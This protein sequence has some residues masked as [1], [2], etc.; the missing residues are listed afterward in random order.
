[1]GGWGLPQTYDDLKE[2]VG[3]PGRPVFPG[4]HGGASGIATQGLKTMSLRREK[5]L[6]PPR[7]ASPQHGGLQAQ[8]T[9]GV[10]H[11]RAPAAPS[12]GCDRRTPKP[13]R[14]DPAVPKSLQKNPQVTPS[15]P[16][17]LPVRTQRDGRTSHEDAWREEGRAPAGIFYR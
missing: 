10:G 13:R 11:A 8:G 17:Q 15:F 7:H 14:P 9:R 16:P 12:Q 4:H 5:E 6:K 3:L 1:M 2:V